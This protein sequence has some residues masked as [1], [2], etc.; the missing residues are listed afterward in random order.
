MKDKPCIHGFIPGQCAIC[1]DLKKA[2]EEWKKRWQ[3]LS[4]RNQ[5]QP[6]K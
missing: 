1:S 6:Q 2:K 4:R 5:V 3:Q